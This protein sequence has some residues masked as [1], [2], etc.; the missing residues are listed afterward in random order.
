MRTRWPPVR[1]RLD[2]VEDVGLLR[3]GAH[4]Q[5]Q[6]LDGAP[7]H[8]GQLDDRL[9]E[10]GGQ[11]VDHEPA[12][13]LEVCGGL[14][15]SRPRQTR[16]HHDVG[17]PRPAYRRRPARPCV[18]DRLAAR[19]FRRT[20]RSADA[21]SSSAGDGRRRSGYSRPGPGSPAGGAGS[22][23]CS[24]S[25]PLRRHRVHVAAE[26]AVD[27]GDEHVL[28]DLLDRLVLDEVGPDPPVLLGR[29]EDLV[30]DPAA[31][32]RLQQ[33]VVEEEEEA[34]AG[35]Q[36]AGDLGDGLVDVADVLEHEAGDDGVE[37]AVGERQ[38]AGARPGVGRAAAPLAAPPRSGSTSGRCRRPRR[39]P[40]DRASRGT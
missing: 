8:A 1:R 7:R 27:E 13:V 20:A 15:A 29:V 25:R 22:A 19:S 36:D 35:P 18:A 32:R 34:A 21:A 9:D 3:A 37:A 5:G 28:L 30:V 11:V 4:D 40:I 24:I 26:R 12:L 17:H 6:P 14:G 23:M 10:R 33:R 39:R 16:D 38:R 2:G 31:V